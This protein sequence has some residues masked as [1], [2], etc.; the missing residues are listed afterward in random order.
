MKIFLP[1]TA[2]MASCASWRAFSFAPSRL[3]SMNR[4]QMLDQGVRNGV[5]MATAGEE[6][7]A[8]TPSSTKANKRKRTLPARASVVAAAYLMSSLLVADASAKTDTPAFLE[9]TD[10]AGTNQL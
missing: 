8:V 2:L 5:L 4:K 9:A 6:Q 7:D 3:P 10:F 1:L